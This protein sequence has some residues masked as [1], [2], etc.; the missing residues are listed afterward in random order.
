MSS[1]FSRRFKAGRPKK[2]GRYS[3]RKS[4]T[5]WRRAVCHAGLVE[6]RLPPQQQHRRRWPTF[7]SYGL[8]QGVDVDVG[9]MAAAFARSAHGSDAVLPHVR[10]GH[11][12]AGFATR[13]GIPGLSSCRLRDFAAVA[14]QREVFPAKQQDR[15]GVTPLRPWRRRLAKRTIRDPELHAGGAEPPARSLL[16]EQLPGNQALIGRPFRP[17]DEGQVTILTPSPSPRRALLLG[18]GGGSRLWPSLR[19]AFS[20]VR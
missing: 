10:Q 3:G 17:E 12:R 5:P 14:S 19:P 11:W 6:T 18:P 8:G 2:S 20:R 16:V 7:G 13:H 15:I 9:F 4:G 1:V